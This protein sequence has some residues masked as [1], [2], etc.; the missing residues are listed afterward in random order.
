MSIIQKLTQLP[1][2]YTP[3]SKKGYEALLLNF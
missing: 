3:A 2:K 1:M